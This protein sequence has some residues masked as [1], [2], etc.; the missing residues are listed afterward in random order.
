MAINLEPRSGM[1]INF[2]ATT[3]RYIGYKKNI[4][5]N[6]GFLI[7]SR[8]LSGVLNI[9]SEHC[10]DP[11]LGL[12]IV[13]VKFRPYIKC[14][15]FEVISL[16]VMRLLIKYVYHPGLSYG[17]FTLGYGMK[18]PN[19]D[20][21]SYTVGSAISLNDS[22]G[23]PIPNT[24]VYAQIELL[25]RQ[26]AEDYDKEVLSGLFLR[27]YYEGR[28]EKEPPLSD[29]E[30]TSKLMEL[31][32]S[33]GVGGGEPQEVKDMSVKEHRYPGHI[34]ALKPTS[35]ER[36]PFIVADTE[37]VLV[38]NVHVPYA[39]GFLVVGEP[40][41][42]TYFSED[43]YLFLPEFEERSHYMLTQF[44]D[45]LTLAAE[46]WKIRTVYF[47]NFSRFDGILLMK[48]YASSDNKYTIKPLMRNQMV[49]ELSV[50]RGKKLVLRFR[51][52]LNLLPGSL[53]TLA[54]TLCPQLGPKGSISHEKVQVS[55]LKTLRPQLVPYLEQ[56]IRLLGGVMLKAQEIY[57]TQ[58]KID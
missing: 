23:R 32:H 56:D 14:V 27:V 57:W 54:K 22:H 3:G 18:I 10:R 24:G 37:T 5:L 26:K 52:S 30:I 45:N 13:E 36:Q 29:E 16:A 8:G 46:K 19:G 49:Y 7:C 28:L 15:G 47:H 6:I 2:W 44:I 12:R 43:Y 34:P 9:E 41:I 38:Q 31:I 55:N 1:A 53:D 40:F 50:Y 17:K 51:D 11:Y 48:H 4:R 21:V 25:A 39:V 20:D 33:G 35:K 42:R 58:F